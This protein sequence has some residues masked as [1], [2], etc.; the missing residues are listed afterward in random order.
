M[1]EQIIDI[2]IHNQNNSVSQ[3]NK[4]RLIPLG[5][6]LVELWHSVDRITNESISDLWEWV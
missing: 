3:H 1:D 5:L 4:D 2:D 6:G